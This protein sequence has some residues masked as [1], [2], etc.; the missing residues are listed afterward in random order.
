MR[1][2]YC[3]ALATTAMAAQTPAP[4]IRSEISNVAVS[5]LK[6]S[7][8]PLGSTQFDAGRM[9]SDAK[10]N[11]MSI[12]FNRSAAQE[13]DLQALIAAQQDP[14]SPQYHQWLSP[15]QFGARFGMA[16]SDI[17][18][19]QTWLQQQ[20]F[21]VDSV[22]RGRNMI[23]FSGTVG[24]VNQAFQTEMHYF[25]VNG[26]NAFCAGEAALGA[27]SH[28]ADHGRSSKYQRLQAAADACFHAPR[29]H[30][31]PVRQRVLCA[32]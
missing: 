21:S 27:D 15:E 1:L 5:P 22:A 16:Q 32:G 7:Q 12:V 31:E 13:A 23:R 20:G 6:A 19:V 17:D 10:I 11:G 2:D 26:E 14:Q 9:P 28:R 18:Q 30:F 8:Q 29:V 24:Q 25:K 4:R 3:I